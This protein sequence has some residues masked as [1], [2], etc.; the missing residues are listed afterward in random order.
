MNEILDK[1]LNQVAA[2]TTLAV[3]LTTGGNASDELLTAINGCILANVAKQF[4]E[5]QDIDF[6]MER[7][8]IPT[9]YL[10]EALE[11]V[12][13]IARMAAMAAGMRD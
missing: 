6:A 4:K 5:K 9:E 8:E 1:N 10:A 2:T 13:L 11:R 12:M 7:H 3:M